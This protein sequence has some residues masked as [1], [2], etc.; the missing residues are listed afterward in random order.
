MT[1]IINLT[2]NDR[3]LRLTLDDRSGTALL[4]TATLE[5]HSGEWYFEDS[6]VITWSLD[7]GV[8]LRL[9]ERTTAITMEKR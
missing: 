7:N 6:S 8:P 1:A 3:S 5:D 4:D 2:L 9:N